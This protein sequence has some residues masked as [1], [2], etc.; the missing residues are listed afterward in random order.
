[1]KLTVI[2]INLNNK[3]GLEKTLASIESQSFLDFEYIL[4]DGDSTDGSLEVIEQYKNRLDYWI[5]EKDSGIYNAMNKGIQKAKGEYLLFLNSGDCLLHSDTLLETI[6]HLGLHDI[7]YGNLRYD[8]AG[9]FTDA[10]YPDKLSF[11]YLYQN[12]LPHP[13][14]F[15]KKE[16]LIKQGLYDESYKICA[17]W[18]FFM[19]AIFLKGASYLHIHQ[20]IS[21]YD[22][23]GLSA[24]A[25]HQLSINKERERLIA[26]Y[27]QQ[28]VADFNHF[29]A[30]SSS[31]Y[32]GSKFK[33]ALGTLRSLLQYPRLIQQL[34]QIDSNLFFVFPSWKI[35][36]SE[37]VHIDILKVVKEQSPTC[38]ITELQFTQG[39]KQE[40]EKTSNV[41]YLWRWGQKKSLKNTLL[42]KTAEAI[43]KVPNAVVFGS[44]NHFF[45]DLIPYLRD[46]VKIVDLT[47]SFAID[48][49]G[50][51]KYNL[52]YTARMN[53]RIVLGEQALE[54][55]RSL[56]AS[57]SVNP[58]LLE[59]FTIIPNQVEVPEQLPAKNYNEN[60]EI[61]FVSRN[62]KEKRPD[63]FFRIVDVCIENSLK[64]NFTVIGDFEDEY[65]QYADKVAFKG[66]LSDPGDLNKYYKQGHLI[67]ITSAFEGFPMVLLEGMAYGVIPISTNVGEIPH[68]IS[69]D[70]QTGFLIDNSITDAQK[71]QQFMETIS[72]LS[73]QKDKMTQFAQRAH[74]LVK[75]DFSTEKF[76]NAYLEI[77]NRP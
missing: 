67:V 70:K 68:F 69:E 22:T 58:S 49:D 31:A 34:N 27:F 6:P 32:K 72:Q 57:N 10:S 40:F 20:V 3:L 54:T 42:K 35:G 41:I 47:H 17:D 55:F 9:K 19:K 39:L 12:Y 5:S 4:I 2:T 63:L 7:V 44:N 15:I 61:L 29:S 8:R 24:Q 73:Q 66:E 30:M 1:M 21:I 56:Y 16:S 51:E 53:T 75:H 71:V 62:S 76:R 37:R 11:G 18:V 23:L 64:V 36:G 50:Y 60:I 46:H 33:K 45:Y 28:Q 43:N 74:Q 26:D 65:P 52:P 14:S 59:R 25:E 77:L 38:I 13:A 48:F